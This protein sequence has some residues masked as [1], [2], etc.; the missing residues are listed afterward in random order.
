[1]SSTF[2][3]WDDFNWK[4]FS[5]EASGLSSQ[6]WKSA[7][8]YE[9][10]KETAVQHAICVYA[11]VSASELQASWCMLTSTKKKVLFLGA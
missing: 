6:F 4:S 7:M 1:M 9:A 2:K 11:L 10:L 8:N 3:A 5:T